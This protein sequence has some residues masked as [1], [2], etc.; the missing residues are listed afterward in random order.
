M[1]LLFLLCCCLV[2]AAV[3]SQQAVGFTYRVTA[4][5]ASR[6]SL[7]ANAGEILQRIDHGDY[8][9]WATDANWQ[10]DHVMTGLRY[11]I[12]DQESASS[13]VYDLV[14]RTENPGLADFPLAG[15]PAA[16]I[17][18]LTL[19]P[20]CGTN[21]WVVTVTF[22]SPVHLPKDREVFLG[23]GV[24]PAPAWPLEGVSLWVSLGDLPG[25]RPVGQGSYVLVRTSAGAYQY[26]GPRQLIVDVLANVPGGVAM[27]VTNQTSYPPSNTPPGTAS[28]Y[29]GLHPDART[30]PAHAGRADDIGYTFFDNS[31]PPGTS[32]FFGVTLAG[33][34]P[35]KSFWANY[36]F[37]V[38]PASV[39]QECILAAN[40]FTLWVGATDASGVANYTWSLT[41]AQR[42]VIGGLDIVWQGIAVLPPPLVFRAGPCARQ[43]F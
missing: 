20:A 1:P 7:G 8:R 28:F 21:A 10:N 30:I 14:F 42:T 13:E 43:Q 35:A 3:P 15:A 36:G 6:G 22:A 41:A 40:W 19:P 16:A 37:P 26:Q 27:A 34:N 33:F 25:P 4:S 11:T 29:S 18:G 2:A 9:G 17:T 38:L 32:V 24:Q 39:G 23:F 5:G 31:L 12:Q